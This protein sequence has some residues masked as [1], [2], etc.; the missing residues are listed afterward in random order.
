MTRFVVL[1]IAFE[2]AALAPMKG[3]STSTSGAAQ[4]GPQPGAAP[5]ATAPPKRAV[6]RNQKT[7]NA[8]PTKRQFRQQPASDQAPQ[9][10]VRHQPRPG[11]VQSEGFISQQQSTHGQRARNDA[12][13][14]N[15]RQSPMSFAQAT[16]R[17]HHQ[18]HDHAWWKNHF[19]TIVFVVNCGY[20]YWDAGYWFPALG[21]YP[22]YEN[23]DYNG[24]IYTYGNL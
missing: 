19:N 1:L 10:Q 21:Y 12:P 14:S 18:R 9:Q 4:V 15:S 5:M 20:Y 17:Q 23:F 13:A 11:P 6:V 24:P 7:Q 3:Q 8:G 22:Q 16:Q 2:F